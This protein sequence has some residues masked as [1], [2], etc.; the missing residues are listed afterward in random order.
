[1]LWEKQPETRSESAACLER[2][3]VPSPE[4]VPLEIMDENVEEVVQWLYGGALYGGMD[5]VRLQHWILHV[6][7]SSDNL[8]QGVALITEWLANN[9][10]PWAGYFTLMISGLIGLDKYPGVCPF[11]IGETWR[12]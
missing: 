12:R 9:H 10:P 6:G 1:M 5:V 4:L 8:W 2:Y 3:A 11:M 7:E